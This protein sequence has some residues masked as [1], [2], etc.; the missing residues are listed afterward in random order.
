[1]NGGGS[2]VRGGAC[3]A[4]GLA[5]IGSI[6]AVTSTSARAASTEVD[7]LQRTRATVWVSSWAGNAA[8]APEKLVDGKLETAWNGRSRKLVGTKVGFFVPRAATV[9][10]I[11]L[12]V[13]FTATHPKY[14]DLFVKNQR[15][16]RVE[17]TREG[18][19]LGSFALDPDKRTLQPIVLPAGTRGGWFTLR[20]AALKAGTK[21]WKEV[22]ISELRAFGQAPLALVH[23]V[24]R[25]PVLLGRPLRRGPQDE[26]CSASV[27]TRVTSVAKVSKRALWAALLPRFD[28]KRGALRPIDGRIAACNGLRQ[29]VDWKE[30][31]RAGQ[32]KEARYS[33][34]DGRQLV[35]LEVGA[36]EMVYPVAGAGIAHGFIAT[37]HL[38]RKAHRVVIDAV[39][40]WLHHDPQDTAG[41]MVGRIGKH[42]AYAASVHMSGTGAG[43]ASGGYEIHVEDGARIQNLTSLQ[44]YSDN[45]D[46]NG[47][48]RVGKGCKW[49]DWSCTGSVSFFKG[50]LR[51][52]ERCSR[53]R[54]GGKACRKRRE[55]KQ[56]TTLY[57]YRAGK[58]VERP[59]KR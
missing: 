46:E 2:W 44:T 49:A 59:A 16:T 25:P 13:G 11:E 6:M 42:V 7:L 5:A 48:E 35:L 14:G 38:D 29:S 45:T 43:G 21:T 12:T 4:W 58:L 22:C 9:T 1:M 20:V 41:S 30:V 27:P 34:H 17:L 19:S 23:R 47:N 39:G 32:I 3:V 40:I 26:R 33:L 57:D 50:A 51:H 56:T 36:R 31:G 53:R 8:Y 24:E 28:V 18:K 15:I 10:R 55:K 37:A 54:Q 52:D